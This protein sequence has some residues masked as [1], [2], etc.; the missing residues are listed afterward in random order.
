VLTKAASGNAANQGS[1]LDRLIANPTNKFQFTA[2]LRRPTQH[3]G[4]TVLLPQPAVSI[5]AKLGIG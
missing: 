2:A 5:H 4:F 1:D 3:A